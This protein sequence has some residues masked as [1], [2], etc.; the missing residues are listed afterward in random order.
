M[1]DHCMPK[2]YL[3]LLSEPI[4]Y[5]TLSRFNSQISARLSS[6]LG[7]VAHYTK[8]IIFYYLISLNSVKHW[9]AFL[10]KK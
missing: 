4:N 9:F 2:T 8:K 5:A 10:S 1:I 3:L 6:S 7:Q